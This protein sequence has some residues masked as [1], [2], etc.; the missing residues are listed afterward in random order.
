MQRTLSSIV[1]AR[2]L[3][4]ALVAASPVSLAQFGMVP[5]VTYQG[6][7]EDNG[8]PV[9]GNVDLVFSFFVSETGGNPIGVTPILGPVPVTDGR[10]TVAVPVESFWIE[11]AAW[12]EIEVANPSGNGT[13]ERLTPRQRVSPTPRALIADSVVPEALYW[14]PGIMRGSGFDIVYEDGRVGIGT[15]GPSAPLDVEDSTG[16][17]TIRAT[18]R[19]TANGDVAVLGEARG[20]AGG[21]TGVWGRS[22]LSP[23][24]TGV[25]GVALGS[26][27]PTRGVH[28]IVES[29][30]G[31]AVHA[32]HIAGSGAGRALWASVDSTFGYAGFFEGGRNHFEGNIGIG[33]QLDPT[34]LIDARGPGATLRAQATGGSAA[35][36]R[37]EREGAGESYLA[38]GNGNALYFN[39]NASDRMVLTSGGDLGL[40]T[41]TPGAR[42]DIVQGGSL[43]VGARVTNNA[44]GVGFEAQMNGPDGIGVRAAAPSGS[45]VVATTMTGLGIDAVAT[46]SAGV[47]VQGMA[48]AGSGDAIGVRGTTNS[49]AGAGVEGFSEFGGAGV[50]GV[51]QAGGI[52][53]HA[54]G[55]V[56]GEALRA[57][58]DVTINGTLAK[59]AGSFR[60]DHPLDPKNRYLS[61]SFVVSPDMMN[62]YNGNVATDDEGFAE[63]EMP[64]WFDALN[65]DFRY[66]LTVI[67]S[68]ARATIGHKI[69]HGR[70]VILTE[71]P[72]VEVSWQVTGIRDD[73]YARAHPI[74]VESDKPEGERGRYQFP[75]WAQHAD[76]SARGR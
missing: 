29:V 1:L 59:S 33:T 63:V 45:A 30:D 66:Q 23:D 34:Y 31:S 62:I 73:P 16:G 74:P 40:G 42:V 53:V 32:Q 52:G 56:T 27:G 24:G 50:R 36:L 13:F 2:V 54:I 14:Q 7:L 70:F 3:V 37:L 12:M 51:S 9:T 26:P 35:F 71:E 60:I 43:D 57:D 67:G 11:N 39:I 75:E 17:P 21:V 18:Q 64:D 5:D 69:E 55:P 58:G 48:T 6:E 28:G 22:L 61:H 76:V 72:N 8:L 10:F 47:G 19:G 44:G 41:Q 68:F 65:R 46:A 4:L 25:L 38:F 49:T 15:P 20:T